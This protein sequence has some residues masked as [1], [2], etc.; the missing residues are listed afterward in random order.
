MGT[1]PDLTEYHEAVQ[2]P[3]Q[4]FTD[5]GLKQASI[6]LDRF[7]MPKPATGGN[8]VV[9]RATESGHTWAIRCFLRPISDHA[10]R[11]ET[12]AKHLQKA[13]LRYSTRFHFMRD[14]IQVRGQQ[15][16]VVKMEWVEGDLLHGYIERNLGNREAFAALR[17]R[18][19]TMMRELEAAKFAHGD[20]QHGNIV[21]RGDG[22]LLIDYD[23][24]WVPALNGR[25]AIELGHRAYQ[26]PKRTE[27]Q[28]GPYQDRFSA[29]VIYLSIAALEVKAELWQEYHTG[30]NL[31]LVR[32]DFRD[33]GRTAIWQSLAGVNSDEID[34]LMDALATCIERRPEDM[35][36]LESV[37]TKHKLGKQRLVTAASPQAPA[38]GLPAWLASGAATALPILDQAR[39]WQVVW[40]RPGERLES[41]W[42]RQA[43]TTAD[44]ASTV[45]IAAAPSRP[46]GVVGLVTALRRKNARRV[47]VEE[48]A[49]SQVR[50][51][52]RSVAPGMESE[53]GCIQGLSDGRQLAV[54][55][56][57]GQCGFWNVATDTFKPSSARL[58]GLALAAFAPKVPTAIVA[59]AH[60]ASVWDIAG[61]VRRE[62]PV[63]GGSEIRS[64]AI[65]TGASRAAI[66]Y[67]GSL[68]QV[69]DVQARKVVGELR[70]H[71]GPVSAL[72]FS[73]DGLLLVSGTAAG[74]VRLFRLP[75]AE[76]VGDGFIHTAPIR[77][78]AA[79]PV[80]HLLASADAQ[81]IVT[82]WGRD[83]QR[84]FS[85]PLCHSGVG[86]LCFMGE[87]D[88]ALAAGC[89]DGTIK[90][91]SVGTGRNV[92]S[93][94]LGGAPVTALWFC[95]DKPGLAAGTAEGKVGLIA[96][97]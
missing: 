96:M 39:Q 76:K 84:L 66:G 2:H 24:V 65:S 12:I 97:S 87:R 50:E 43:P 47:E 18:W 86:T 48:E 25:G 38:G 35:P 64:V 10:E 53:V 36:S 82:V 93:F 62:C 11:Y 60:E 4:A 92:A 73:S 69:L 90:V 42:K 32:D 33:V 78:V 19:R 59:N 15:Y 71:G 3:S 51:Q 58:P 16:P 5:P 30:D 49:D 28:F 67:E 9:Y 17:E 46:S 77:A 54:V 81:G 37:L 34:R 95:K 88:L 74:A 31:I 22:L 56:K 83:M 26:H 75:N 85:V 68:V 1:W 70:D 7:G 40:S 45:A 79:A 23:G 72:A 94:R 41:R 27:T 13:K 80:G 63:D 29:L 57:N 55:A 14:G 52:V 21:V 8:A 44:D 89:N 91:I 20:L 6:E 61:W